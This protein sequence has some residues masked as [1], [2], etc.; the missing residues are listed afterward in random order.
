MTHLF[1]AVS[2]VFGEIKNKKKTAVVICLCSTNKPAFGYSIMFIKVCIDFC[3]EIKHI[4]GSLLKKYMGT[5]SLTNESYN[6]SIH[7]K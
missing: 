3:K 4:K 1:Q 6:T 5:Q 7:I 2:W